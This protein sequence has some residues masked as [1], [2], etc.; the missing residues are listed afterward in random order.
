[1]GFG[2][3]FANQLEMGF[4]FGFPKQSLR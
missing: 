2:F 1:M 3:G 4:H